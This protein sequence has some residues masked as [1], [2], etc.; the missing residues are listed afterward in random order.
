M[1]KAEAASVYFNSLPYEERATLAP[2]LEE[3]R[4]M[5]M[6]EYADEVGFATALMTVRIANIGNKL[7]VEEGSQDGR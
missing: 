4:R 3:Y 6:R 1:T 5:G 2:L 7:D